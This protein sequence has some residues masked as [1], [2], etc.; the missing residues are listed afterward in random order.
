MKASILTQKLWDIK[1]KK[2]REKEKLNSKQMTICH[3]RLQHRAHHVS[4]Q[5]ISKAFSHWQHFTKNYWHRFWTALVIEMQNAKWKTKLKHTHTNRI[6]WN[7]KQC[8]AKNVAV[9]SEEFLNHIAKVIS[10]Y[11]TLANIHIN[12]Y[13]YRL[14]SWIECNKLKFFFSKT[15]TQPR[16]QRDYDKLFTVR[17]SAQCS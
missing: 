4:L 14:H 1:G 9:I 13:H 17:A 10:V 6:K 7:V 16:N 2:T 15:H 11:V 5:H 3:V 8:T 12:S